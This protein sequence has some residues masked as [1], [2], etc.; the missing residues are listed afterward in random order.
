[1]SRMTVV[2]RRLR[3]EETRALLEVHHAAVRGIAATDYPPEVVEAWAPMPVTDNVVADVLVNRDNEIRL[4]AVVEDEIVGIAAV[5]PQRCELRACYVTPRAARRGVGT[6][7]VRE[8]E[9][10]ARQHHAAFLELDSSLTAEQFYLGLGY[11]VRERGT[12]AL[13]SGQLMAC[14]KMR[15]DL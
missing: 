12:H 3:P 9:R 13:G 6:M 2:V 11:V 8:M 15:K 10:T 14:I 7:L 4:A 5:I 1:M